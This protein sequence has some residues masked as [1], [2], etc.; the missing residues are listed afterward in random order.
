ML[1]RWASHCF[2]SLFCVA[3][4]AMKGFGRVVLAGD[5]DLAIASARVAIFRVGPTSLKVVHQS[6]PLIPSL[7]L[8]RQRQTLKIRTRARYCN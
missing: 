7:E 8:Q 6:R 3:R 5:W 1:R 2:H 4:L